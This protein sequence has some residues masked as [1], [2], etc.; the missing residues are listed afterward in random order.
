MEPDGSD[1]SGRRPRPAP[2]APHDAPETRSAIPARS[3]TALMCWYRG[4]H[5]RVRKRVGHARSMPPKR[6]LSGLRICTRRRCVPADRSRHRR[7]RPGPVERAEPAPG[8]RDRVDLA[9]NS[10]S[11]TAAGGSGDERRRV[12]TRRGMPLSLCAPWSSNVMPDPA[13]RST[14]VGDTRTSPGCAR[15]QTRLARWTVMPASSVRRRSTSPVWSPDPDVDVDLASRVADRGSRAARLPGR[16]SPPRW[17]PEAG[18]APA[19]ETTQFKR[20]AGGITWQCNRAVTAGVDR[21]RRRDYGV[22]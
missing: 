10:S 1:Q 3:L 22:R 15:S 9:R 6:R 12:A 4:Q 18:I 5:R 13:T 2:T 21:H 20:Q 7:P 14:T 8:A 17:S 11:W 16:S 19:S